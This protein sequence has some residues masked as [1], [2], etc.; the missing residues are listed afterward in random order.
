VLTAIQVRMLYSSSKEAI[1]NA[2]NG[3]HTDIQANDPEDIEFD[4]VKEKVSRGR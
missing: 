4:T 2:L 3:I 1:K